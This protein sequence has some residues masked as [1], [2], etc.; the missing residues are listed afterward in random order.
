MAQKGLESKHNTVA[1]KKRN[2]K[3]STLKAPRQQANKVYKF[4]LHTLQSEAKATISEK[5]S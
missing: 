1:L 3:Y 2:T 5:H 4:Q